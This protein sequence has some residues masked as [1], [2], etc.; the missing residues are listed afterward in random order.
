M[1][2]LIHQVGLSDDPSLG[3]Y[4]LFCPRCRELYHCPQN[5]RRKQLIVDFVFVFQSFCQCRNEFCSHINANYSFRSLLVTDVDGAYFGTSFAHIFLMTYDDLVPT[6]PSGS[7]VPRV[8]G[9]KVHS[10]S[11]SL[12]KKVVVLDL[13]SQSD[14]DGGHSSNPLASSGDSEGRGKDKGSTKALNNS[15]HSHA[16][17][18]GSHGS[19]GAPRASSSGVPVVYDLTASSLQQS[20]SGHAEASKVG[21]NPRLSLQPP[22]HAKYQHP[23]QADQGPPGADGYYP[24]PSAQ[25]EYA[26]AGQFASPQFAPHYAPPRQQEY[27]PEAYYD[28]LARHHSGPGGAPNG[29]PAP[30]PPMPGNGAY[31]E[32][33][34]YV[35]YGY[36]APPGYAHAR[37]GHSPRADADEDPAKRPRTHL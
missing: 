17:H 19:N 20:G 33:G 9:F 21:G 2:M 18:H 8:F 3:C 4:K 7:Y 10:S 30:Q 37:H 22:S 34:Q 35:T 16:S 12:P 32:Y 5:Q 11:S 1:F 23:H 14:G 25:Y 6:A 31:S 36:T 26:A 29:Y 13:N 15:H 24:A 27:P 28:A